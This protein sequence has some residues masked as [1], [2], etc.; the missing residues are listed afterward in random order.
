MEYDAEV[1]HC[2]IADRHRHY[3]TRQHP[4]KSPAQ[5]VVHHDQ[6]TGH[7][8]PF[9]SDIRDQLNVTSETIKPKPWLYGMRLDATRERHR[10]LTGYAG[11]SHSVAGEFR[12]Q[13]LII[14][15]TYKLAR[16]LRLYLQRESSGEIVA[17]VPL[18]DFTTT[19]I[20]RTVGL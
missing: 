14:R 18:C 7:G 4:E 10:D 13:D 11:I 15:F 3:V 19:I 6:R 12:C 20:R 5:L 17:H 8:L 2:W 9:F 1:R 16:T